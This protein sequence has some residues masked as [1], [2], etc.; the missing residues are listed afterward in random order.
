MLHVG[1]V[2][3][4]EEQMQDAGSPRYLSQAQHTACLICDLLMI[5][6]CP[7]GEAD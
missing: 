4:F 3:S 2:Q 6:L 5:L 7:V 1:R